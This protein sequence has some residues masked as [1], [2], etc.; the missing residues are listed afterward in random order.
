MERV[1]AG[2]DQKTWK[3][4]GTSKATVRSV[5]RSRIS[6]LCNTSVHDAPKCGRLN[7]LVTRRYDH[8]LMLKFAAQDTRLLYE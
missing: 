1:E 4:L 3:N 8:N 2:R 7:E 5:N 6:V